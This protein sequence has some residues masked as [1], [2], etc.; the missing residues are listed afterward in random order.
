[1]VARRGRRLASGVGLQAICDRRAGG[2]LTS[3]LQQV[4]VRLCGNSSRTQTIDEKYLFDARSQEGAQIR[5]KGD[6]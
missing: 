4:I 1:M 5:T 3:G 2:R 6:L